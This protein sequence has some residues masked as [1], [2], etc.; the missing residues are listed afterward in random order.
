M[1]R[2][3]IRD[4]L[5]LTLVVG[6]AVGWWLSARHW[7]ASNRVLTEKNQDLLEEARIADQ[8][9]KLAN[10]QSDKAWAAAN[11]PFYRPPSPL[12]RRRAQGMTP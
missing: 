12:F 2:F 6:L 9:A 8:R 4:L 11:D 3:T 1:A 7:L 10:E 5:W